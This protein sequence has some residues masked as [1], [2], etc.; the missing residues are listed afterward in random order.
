MPHVHHW[1]WRWNR[2]CE[3]WNDIQLY[4]MIAHISS[5]SG[6]QIT[7]QINHL[8]NLT[9]SLHNLTVEYI[10]FEWCING[11]LIIYIPTSRGPILLAWNTWWRHQ[12]ETF[13]ALLV[14]GPGELPTQRPVTQSFDAFFDL[15]L[16]KRLSKQSW[17]WWFETQSRT[18]WRQ[19]NN[20]HPSIDKQ[21]HPLLS[22]GWTYLAIPKLQRCSRWSL[23]MD[24]LFHPTL[25]W[26]CNYLSMLVD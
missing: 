15:R 1:K 5:L 13:S 16:N 9:T 4:H 22:L 21:S 23:G 7:R 18:L 2:T 11:K 6:D 10:Y 12:M 20:F 14:T 24:K 8:F 3:G 17:S 26:A 25:N 19:C